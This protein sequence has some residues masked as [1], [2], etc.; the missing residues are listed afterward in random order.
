MKKIIN[1]KRYDTTTARYV[2]GW[3]NNRGFRDFSHCYEDLYCKKTGEYFLYGAGGPMSKYA[4]STGQNQWSGGEDIV[5]MTAE[6]ARE[7][8]EEKLPP[9]KYE[10]EFTV[11]EDEPLEPGT[12]IRELR[13]AAGLTQTD[14]AGLAGMAQPTLADI[15]GGKVDPKLT[16]LQRIAKALN[17]STGELLK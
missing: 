6:E 9:E 7:W 5:L 1:G 14:L 10:A 15:E 11:I 3:N 16:S 2:G 17:V 8:A 13:E 12:R 4:E